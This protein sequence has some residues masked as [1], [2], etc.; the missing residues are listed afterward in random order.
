MARYERAGGE[1]VGESSTQL[2]ESGTSR[3]AAD[4]NPIALQQQIKITNPRTKYRTQ[5]NFMEELRRPKGGLSNRA[6]SL[7]RVKRLQPGPRTEV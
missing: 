3:L 5:L 6:Q 7:R 2:T 1:L 4:P